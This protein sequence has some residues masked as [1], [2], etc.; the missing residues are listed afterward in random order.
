MSHAVAFVL[1]L[2]GVALAQDE[3][4]LLGEEIIKKGDENVVRKISAYPGGKEF[5]ERALKNYREGAYKK[6][7]WH[8]DGT[9]AARK[10]RAESKPLLVVIV[11]NRGARKGAAD[12]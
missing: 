5:C 10:A 6:I 3:R 4:P 9:A 11:A 2:S 12:C 8:K 1:L 7:D